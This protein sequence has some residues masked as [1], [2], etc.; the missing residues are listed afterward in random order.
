MS[1]YLGNLKV[2]SFSFKFNAVI[3]YTMPLGQYGAYFDENNLELIADC[4]RM[5]AGSLN[6]KAM[7][8]DVRNEAYEA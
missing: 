4:H 5:V 8:V 6:L 7:F 3:L 1:K 2:G